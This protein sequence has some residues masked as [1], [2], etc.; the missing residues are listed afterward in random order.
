MNDLQERAINKI[1]AIITSKNFEL[2][3]SIKDLQSKQYGG[4]SRDEQVLVVNGIIKEI[5]VFE[6]ILNALNT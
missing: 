1:D 6:H 5:E 3:V 4:V 2:D